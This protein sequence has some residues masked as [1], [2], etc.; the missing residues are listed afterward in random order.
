MPLPIAILMQLSEKIPAVRKIH[1]HRLFSATSVVAM[2]LNVIQVQIA[3]ALGV[4]TRNA[5]IPIAK[6]QPQF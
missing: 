5:K 6:P 3:S 1:V 2:E 4:L